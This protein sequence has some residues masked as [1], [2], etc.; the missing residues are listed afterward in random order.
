ME[1]T[2][3]PSPRV[4]MGLEAVIAA[5]ILTVSVLA[6]RS[7]WFH[8]N[9]QVI[10]AA[11]AFDLVITASVVHWLMGVRVA[12]APAWTVTVVAVAGAAVAGSL[13]PVGPGLGAVAVGLAAVELVAG[14][15]ALTRFRT[16][17]GAART[18]R[19]A[20]ANRI[21]A[22]ERGLDAALGA[23]TLARAVSGELRVAWL[24]IWGPLLPAPTTG[25]TCHREV[26]WFGLIG[27]V[28]ALSVIE[29][30]IGHMFVAHLG[31]PHLAWLVTALSV[32][33][34][35]WLWGD[36]QALRLIRTE[37]GTGTLRLRVGMRWAADIPLSEIVA[38]ERA[39]DRDALDVSIMQPNVRL[40]FAAPVRVRGLLGLE[41]W[42]Q[43]LTLTLDEPERF[44]AALGL[45]LARAGFNGA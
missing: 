43:T 37:I 22:L 20:G 38:V 25:F 29:V 41:R 45:P 44:A 2:R 18:A 3:R 12:G 40:R 13:L 11:V 30:P 1:L 9:P 26:G 14:G 5:V 23:P 6:A 4:A 8:R 7:P 33:G 15:V 35:V 10:G 28:L 31:G 24:A 34:V 32:Y 19:E 42:G 39:D 16:L 36:T 27:T 21:D 17:W